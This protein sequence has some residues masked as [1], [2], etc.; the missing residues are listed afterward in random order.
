MAENNLEL[1][2]EDNAKR[3]RGPKLGVEDNVLWGSR[4]DLVGLF[5][6]TWHDVEW[7][8]RTVKTSPDVRQALQ[9]LE[10]RQHGYVLQTLFRS[11]DSPAT[12]RLLRE[13]RRRLGKLYEAGRIAY[14]SLEK[15]TESF[16]RAIRIPVTQHS[17]DQRAVIDDKVKECAVAL[18]RAGA[19]YL[20]LMDQQAN[21]ERH[22]NDCEAYFA[23]AE[24]VRFCRSHR[25]RLTPLSTA[26]ALAGLPFIGWRQ[27]VKRC[28]KWKRTAVKSLTHEVFEVIQRIVAS[29]IRRAELVS[30]AERWLRNQRSTGW[31]AV[32]ELRRHWYYLSRA[33]R[34]V[35]EQKVPRRKL[36]FSIPSEYW[37]RKNQP[38]PVDSAFYEDESIVI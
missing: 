21:L 28:K 22:R 7:N 27:S 5:E 18:A 34:V 12:P 24:F 16:E 31:D 23:R 1:N 20:G 3:R 17:D 33:I 30:H 15:C 32:A 4:E 35:L 29:N 9:P 8:L 10:Q 36:S 25:Y 6:A 38:S 26:N 19:E 13:Q 11:T 37:K 14:K 2:V